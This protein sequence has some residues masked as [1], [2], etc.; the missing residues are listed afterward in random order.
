MPNEPRLQRQDQVDYTP[1]A[2]PALFKAAMRGAITAA[3]AVFDAEIMVNQARDARERQ[4]A[5]TNYQNKLA[6]HRES[7]LLLRQAQFGHTKTQDAEAINRHKDELADK[8]AAKATTEEVERTRIDASLPG[9]NFT[10]EQITEVE[11]LPTAQAKNKRIGEINKRKQ[12]EADVANTFPHMSDDER[13]IEIYNRMYPGAKEDEDKSPFDTYQKEIDDIESS[14]LPEPEKE[15]MRKTARRRYEQGTHPPA[16]SQTPLEAYMAAVKSINKSTVDEE[17]KGWMRDVER[18]RYEKGAQSGGSLSETDFQALER[19]LKQIDDSKTLDPTMK[20][21]AKENL[22]REYAGLSNLF[23]A[24]ATLLEKEGRTLT[25]EE[26]MLV[27]KIAKGIMPGR[28]VESAKAT[29][30]ALSF[31]VSQMPLKDSIENLEQ[32][33]EEATW[34]TV[35]LTYKPLFHALV[36]PGASITTRETLKDT[37][38]N[39]I[40]R[41]NRSEFLGHVVREGRGAMRD[42]SQRLSVNSNMNVLRMMTDFKDELKKAD[43]R[44][45]SFHRGAQLG[46]WVLRKAGK[47]GDAEWAKIQTKL[48]AFLIGYAKEISGAAVPPAE[49]NRFNSILPSRGE[50]LE[51]NFAKLDGLIEYATT[52]IID[53]YQTQLGAYNMET[54]IADGGIDRLRSEGPGRP[55]KPAYTELISQIL[56][57]PVTPT[58]ATTMKEGPLPF[59]FNPDLTEEAI[60]DATRKANPGVS[61]ADITKYLERI[62]KERRG[63]LAK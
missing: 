36:P 33:L 15:E 50:S 61:D 53:K 47:T 9:L 34:S 40:E 63:H 1:P 2:G 5:E 46:E 19:E 51:L 21:A 20:I 62:F 23:P 35:G 14:D 57:T 29:V 55:D 3:K 59:Y 27:L 52:L 10:P 54:Y 56:G 41:G 28:G 49:Y 13:K 7:E 58:E 16:S 48:T 42:M 18:K 30:E 22:W 8:A 24:D 17:I 12:I 31:Q 37:F 11:G 44:G 25:T 60:E 4:V 26:K 32:R 39:I 38:D 45:V 6:E 43:M